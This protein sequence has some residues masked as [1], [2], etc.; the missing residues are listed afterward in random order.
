MLMTTVQRQSQ[1]QQTCRTY[2]KQRWIE[3]L[4]LMVYGEVS[5]YGLTSSQQF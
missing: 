4:A 2:L 1:T 3:E 5:M